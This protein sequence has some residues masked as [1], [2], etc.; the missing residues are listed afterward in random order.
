MAKFSHLQGLQLAD[1]KEFELHQI[2]VNGVSPVLV[3]KPSTESN[4]PFFNKVLQRMG[5]SARMLRSGKITPAMSAENRKDDR[6]L[7]PKHVIVGWS[8][9]LDTD[10]TIVP[11]SQ[12]E[13]ANFLNAL[14]DWIFD[15]LRAFCNDPANFSETVDVEVAAKNS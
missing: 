4:K 2:S 14:P 12:E 1:T 7:F 6:E 3:V 15:E 13:C 9:V 11:Y 8:N 10:G 5:K